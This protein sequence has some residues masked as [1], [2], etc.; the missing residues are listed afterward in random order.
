MRKLPLIFGFFNTSLLLFSQLHSVTITVNTP[1][2]TNIATDGLYGANI[3]LRG[4]LNQVMT[5]PSDTYDIQFALGIGNETIN[6]NGPLPVL[7]LLTASFPQ[8]INIDGANSGG[9]G[10]RITIDGG[11]NYR[12]L[13]CRQ[14]TDT[15]QNITLQNMKAKGGTGGMTSGGGGLGAGAA[16]LV[17]QATVTLSNV[18]IHNCS[19]TGGDGGAFSAAL[20][21][22]GGG[23]MGGNGGK[24]GLTFTVPASTGGAGGGGGLGGDGGNGGDGA[25]FVSHIAGG[26]GGGGINGKGGD[27]GKITSG[28]PDSPGGGGGGIGVGGTGSNGGKGGDSGGVSPG[29]AGGSSGLFDGVTY[30][31]GGGGGAGNNIPSA[32]GVGGGLGAG[33]GLAGGGGGGGGDSQSGTTGAAGAGGTGG[34]GGGGGGS[35]R[36]AL[37]GSGGDGGGGGGNS[38]NVVGSAGLGGV[39]GWGGGG[40]ARE[41]GGF[42]GGSGGEAGPAIVAGFGGG[43][44]GSDTVYNTTGGTAAASPGGFGA[45]GGGTTRSGQSTK[46]GGVGGGQGNSFSVLGGGGGGAGLGGAILVNS[47]GGLILS[48]T[49]TFSSNLVNLGNSGGGDATSGAAAA[50][51]IFMLTGPNT[52]T[53]SPI[54]PADVITIPEI[55]DDSSN[56]LPGPGYNPGIASGLNVDISGAGSVVLTGANTYSGN[57][58][59]ISGNLFV[60]GSIT[61]VPS[62]TTVD[63]GALLGGAGVIAGTADVS[64]TLAPGNPIGALT[65]GSVIFEPGSTFNIALDPSQSS[66][67]TATTSAVIN[68]GSTLVVTPSPGSYSTMTYTILTAPSLTVVSPFSFTP[69]PGLPFQV[70]YNPKSIQLTLQLNQLIPITPCLSG[71]ALDMAN[72]LNSLSSLSP[73]DSIVNT[74]AGLGCT[75]LVNALDSISPS[76]NSFTTF[77]AQNTM[78]L[79]RKLVSYR[80]STQRLMHIMETKSSPAFASYTNKSLFN[81]KELLASNEEN[82]PSGSTAKLAKRNEKH[83]LWATGVG[84]FS[85]Q[86]AQEQN[87]AFRVNTGGELTGYDYYGFE[88]GVIGAALGFARSNIREE[89]NAGNGSVNYYTASIYGTGYIE[90]AYIETSL[91]G[92]YNKYRNK[93]HVSYLGTSVFSPGLDANAKSSH[94]GYQIAPHLG[95]GYDINWIGNKFTGVLEP[96]AVFDWVFTSENGFSENGPSALNMHQRHRTSSMLRSEVGMNG[97]E[98]WKGNWGVFILRE[99][100]S[101][102]NKKPFNTGKI[103]ASIVGAPGSFTVESFTKA[104][105]LFSPALEVFYRA[106]NGGFCSL[107]YEGEYGSGYSSNEV[108]GE[109]GIFF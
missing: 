14:G 26:G 83:V 31:G 98:S 67:V 3:D 17:D 1:G 25:G 103:R 90:N 12:G 73:F 8:T 37:G 86:N 44:G 40:G 53:L 104:Q 13:V 71:N 106:T 51:D 20:I 94:R 10:T 65:I 109:V 93:R 76:R 59:V 11:N 97:Y 75:D 60:N 96:F 101:Y 29:G 105:N 92:T 88:N 19:S 54:N 99:T 6:L 70:V 2:D 5:Q 57:T 36:A 15:I 72:Y 69:P 107:T 30:V 16:L 89:Q 43:G 49:V 48:N 21:G 102:V 33:S 39:G 85:H 4:A 45:G 80:L 74:L 9:S 23:G 77:A 42:G 27:G 91:W 35:V 87:P 66:V 41:K 100:L 68:T 7:G 61:N 34:A 28:P 24:G 78:F 52:L 47:G 38:S 82:L 55:G 32:G 64:G 62:T 84:E 56:T 81:E 63:L 18:S 22:G 95:L 79:F 50:T 46:L 58:H 108:I